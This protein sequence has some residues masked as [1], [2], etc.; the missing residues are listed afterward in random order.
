[1]I[2]REMYIFLAII[3]QM[4]HDVMDTMKCY[5]LTMEQFFYT[6]LNQH[7]ET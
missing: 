3:I 1:M 4:G 2:V 7:N 5:C 6:I